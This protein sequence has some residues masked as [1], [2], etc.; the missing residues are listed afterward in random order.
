[1]LINEEINQAKAL[2]C[3]FE[4]DCWIT[5]V[6]ETEINGDL[7]L[8]YIGPA[9]LTWHSALIISKDRRTHTIVG[10][11]D[12]RTVQDLEAWDEVVGF[13][14]GIREPLTEYLKELDPRP[15]R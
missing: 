10:S 2:R 7:T 11:Q 12:V 13:V 5:F 8:V 14:T 6:R 4:I 15:L 1:M 9:Q 3:E